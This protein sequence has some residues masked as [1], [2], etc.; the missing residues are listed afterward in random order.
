MREPAPRNFF[1]L[2]GSPCPPC[3]PSL[4]PSP[5]SPPPLESWTRMPRAKGGD[6]LASSLISPPPHF[7]VQFAS[8]SPEPPPPSQRPHCPCLSCFSSSNP[9]FLASAFR[10]GSPVTLLQIFAAATPFIAT[11]RTHFRFEP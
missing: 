5:V 3:P 10:A 11:C 4:P 6:V 7:F 9:L 2:D 1:P 8:I